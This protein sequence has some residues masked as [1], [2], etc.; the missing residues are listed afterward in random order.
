[1]GVQKGLDAIDCS[2]DDIKDIYESE[3]NK[4]VNELIQVSNNQKILVK[5]FAQYIGSV[6][7]I[8][9]N[10]RDAMSSSEDI[11]K[12]QRE[13]IANAIDIF[14]QESSKSF[15]VYDSSKINNSKED[16]E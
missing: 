16:S 6:K 15:M 1:M 14:I 5:C 3:Y 8:L 12:I 10:L 11:T 9:L 2:A 13:E 4:K 7:G